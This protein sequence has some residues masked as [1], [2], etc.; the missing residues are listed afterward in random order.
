MMATMISHYLEELKSLNPEQTVSVP[1]VLAKKLDID[2]HSLVILAY[3]V[4]TIS[5]SKLDLIKN[6]MFNWNADIVFISEAW[7][8]IS[9][10]QGYD[11]FIFPSK[12]MNTLFVRSTIAYCMDINGYGYTVTIND[13]TINFMYIPPPPNSVK[14]QFPNN[15]IIGDINW[16]SNKFS[17]PLYHET[18]KKNTG[19][20]VIN[21]DITPEFLDFP[22]DHQLVKL[23]LN[24]NW[25][26]AKIIDEHAV[27]GK[28]REATKTGHYK[29]PMKVKT[30]R[31]N[32]YSTNFWIKRSVRPN[33]IFNRNMFGRFATQFWSNLY[34]N[35]QNKVGIVSGNINWNKLYRIK[36]RAKDTWGINPNMV[37]NLAS[38]LDMHEKNNLEIALRNDVT[39]NALLLKKREFS[40]KEYNPNNF[41]IISILPSFIKLYEMNFN[42]RELEDRIRPNFIGFMRGQSVDSL[43]GWI[44][45]Y[46]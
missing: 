28:L 18:K 23:K 33:K 9:D 43:I 27:I 35:K 21:C 20:S 30:A 46:C 2:P 31:L 32:Y 24:I 45:K 4:Q 11:K 26:R 7:H 44:N 29:K 39:I 10:I 5:V 16:K 8:E 25:S 41:R 22:S 34:G 3:N 13:Q 6:Q 12:Y 15:I 36:S 1:G 37:Y 19:M 42:N 38:K 40:A 17:E 14:V